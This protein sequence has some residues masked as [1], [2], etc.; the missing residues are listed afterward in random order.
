MLHLLLYSTVISGIFFVSTRGSDP[1]LPQSMAVISSVGERVS[2]RFSCF[3]GLL[4][5]SFES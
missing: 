2:V 1:D 3:H 4:G 5:L